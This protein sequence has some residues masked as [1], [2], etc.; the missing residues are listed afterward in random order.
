MSKELAIFNRIVEQ[1]TIEEDVILG[2]MMSLPGL[3]YNNK[4]FAFYHKGN[5]VF[6]LISSKLL[7]DLGVEYELLSPFKIKPPLK[8]WFVVNSIFVNSWELLTKEALEVMKTTFD[9]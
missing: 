3:K 8:G 2:K 9:K 7:D 4:V 5:M 1:I 6:K